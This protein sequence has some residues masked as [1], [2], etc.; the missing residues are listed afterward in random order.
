MD[1]Y[2]IENFD[3]DSFNI[4]IRDLSQSVNVNL[5]HMIEDLVI[6][7]KKETI[8]KNKKKKV[9][10]KAE[11]IIENQKI[12]KYK[13]DLKNDYKMID[14]FIENIDDDNP[15]TNYNKLKTDV[16]KIDYKFKLLDRY[17]RKKS[18]YLPH[19]FILYFNLNN[20][21]DKY[22]TEKNSKI[23]NKVSNILEDYDYKLYMFE[24]LGHLLPPLNFWNKGDFKFEEWQIDVIK[25]IKQK[26]SIFI[27]APT[28]SG[29][30]FIATACGI[31]HKKVLYV[32]P[33]KPVTYQIGSHFIKMGYKV[34]FILDQ[35]ASMKIDDKTN[36]YIGTPDLIEKYLY[37]IKNNFDYAVYDEI[38]NLTQEYENI[39]HLL[40]CNYLILSATIKNHKDIINKFKNIHPDKKISYI[41]YNERFINQ[42]RWIWDK[43]C[44]NKL[45]PC[46]CLDPTSFKDFSII[47]FTPNDCANL[48][49]RLYSEFEDH[50]LEEY[51]DNFSPDNFFKDDKLLTLNDS[52]I[53]EKKLK[54]ELE[55]IY[56]KYPDKINSVINTYNKIYE[57]NKNETD[58]I[59]LFQCCKKNKMLPL[60]LFHT[61]EK[62]TKEIFNIVY[63]E[64]KTKEIQEYPYHYDILEKKQSL[65]DEYLNKRI[66]YSDNIKIKTNDALTEKNEKLKDFDMNEKMN[67]ISIIS[68][69]YLKCINKCKGTDNEKNKIKN[70]NYEMKKFIKN[71]D[72]RKQDVFKKNSNFCFT[73]IEPMSG[74]EIKEIRK[75]INK[76]TGKK[77][78]YNDPIFQLLKRGIGIY[79]KSNPDEYNWIVQNLMSQK[80]LG[81]IISDKTLCL[82]IDLPIRSV[83]FTGYKNPEFTCEDYLQMSGRSGR[84]GHDNQGNIIFHNVPNYRQ[85]M[86]SKLPQLKFKDDPLF[87]SYKSINHLNPTIDL[88]KLN[89]DGDIV[90]SNKYTLKLLWYL[91]YNKN[92]LIFVNSL[93]DY[94]R[95]LFMVSEI[96]REI[97][98]LQYVNN[99]LLKY[100]M[101]KI[102]S[103]YKN[104]KL[105]N[106]L[107]E[108]KKIMNIFKDMCNSL[109]SMKYKI[110]VDNS[111]II[112][113][114]IKTMLY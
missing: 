8:Q 87:K 103:S 58:F 12:K 37:R 63:E 102:L 68:D 40:K 36:I 57:M 32:C 33:A 74:S 15:Y 109:H 55:V 100:D 85:L 52:K 65:Y 106:N 97:T 101:N 62:K 11:I 111:C 96:D 80:K 99:I 51:I 90:Y 1:T 26:E 56:N 18:K 29:K 69:Y 105:D 5:K 76:A 39:I 54:E 64:L 112:F 88:N 17:W 47:S 25:K 114:K 60:I 70:L 104:N 49:S 41:E 43:S 92:S 6:D 89:I 48:Y 4:F 83:C 35:T 79:I 27:K 113:N 14:F 110:I 50:E 86:L 21:D 67:Y 107:D 46:C 61:D 78:E 108:F 45:H 10:T 19:V 98:L 28:S 23:M 44:I 71:P 73:D 7:N 94:E 30:T 13:K 72:F 9:K 84:R 77:M 34:H 53:Y 82:G 3:R 59:K 91:R 75:K 20:V 24:K 42:Q 38:H 95:K 16:A 22:L 66:N 31:L 81:I 93:D 2:M